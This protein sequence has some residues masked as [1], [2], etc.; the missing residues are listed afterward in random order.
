MNEFI[1]MEK[2]T[3]CFWL[4]GTREGATCSPRPCPNKIC[5][6]WRAVFLVFGSDDRK[7]STT[8]A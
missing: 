7:N 5:H 2:L 6:C 4:R 3:F 1:L 8:V